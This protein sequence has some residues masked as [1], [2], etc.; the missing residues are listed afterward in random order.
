MTTSLSGTT[1]RDELALTGRTPPLFFADLASV[2]A[3]GTAAAQAHHL[4]RAF[5]ALELD[6]IL[7]Q[8]NAP[9]A[10]FREVPRL[11]PKLVSELHRRFWNLGISPLL[12]LID[13]AEVHVY[14]GLAT[15]RPDGDTPAAEDERLVVRL[16][17]VAQALE[18]RQL[19]LAIESGEI[20]HREQHAFD[21]NRRVDRQLLQNLKA[22][23]DAMAAVG[24]AR[25]DPRNLDNFLCRVVFT[26][27]LFDRRV[28]DQRY[29]RDA[30]LASAAT[31]RDLAEQKQL[32]R[33]FARLSEDFNGDL[34][35]D[36]LAAE[37]RE[38]RE[39]H[40]RIL[41][42]FL[43]GTDIVTGQGSFWPYDF[44]VIP[45]ETIS[46][47]YEH[48]LKAADPGAKK[49][50]GAFYTP[51]FLA[52]MTL[53]MALDGMKDLLG[54]R[55]LDPA[56]GSGVFLVGLFNRLAHEW[57][58]R[59]PEA[60]YTRRADGL[61]EILKHNLV[62]ADES[63]TAC[64]IA[65][66]SLYLALLDQLKP[67]QIRELQKRKR[68]LPP[69]VSSASTGGEGGT[70]HCGDFF[71]LPVNGRFDVAVGN[72]P[73]ASLSGP[74][75]PAERWCTSRN[76]P[77]ANRQIALAFVWK[78]AGHVSTDGRICFV[79]PNGVLFNH[80]AKALEFQREWLARHSVESVLNLS[81]F[82]RF[83]FEEAEFPAVVIRYRPTATGT[84]HVSYWSPKTDWR[85]LHAEVVSVAP[86][87]R[88][89]LAVSALLA[90]LKD[91]EAPL[92][93]KVHFWA[94]PRDIK[95][96]DRL[97]MY[98]RLEAITSQ[99]RSRERKRWLAGQGFIPE[100]TGKKPASKPNPWSKDQLFLDAKS[101]AID[102]FVIGRDASA[103]GHRFP[104]LL[105]PRTA[106]EI[107]E[108]PHVLVTKSLRAAYCGYPVLF[109]HA[110]QGIHG[111][112]VDRHLLQF[113]AA[114]FSSPLA[115]F[116]L[117]HTTSSWGVNRAEVHLAELLSAPFPLPV[118][119]NDPKR[120]QSIVAHVSAVV[121][122]AITEAAQLIVDRRSVVEAA[123]REITPLIYEYFD[124]DETERI[125]I[126]D[127]N[128]IVIPST[129]PTNAQSTLAT[130]KPPDTAA[131]ALYVDTLTSTLNHWARGG[132]Q[133]VSGRS[134]TA[135]WSGVGAVEL[136]RFGGAE[137]SRPAGDDK[138][139]LTTL[140]RLRNL[141]RKQLGSVELLRGLKV[142]HEDTL[143]LFKPL[144]MRFWT[145]TAALNDAD[146]IAASILASLPE[147]R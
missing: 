101:D 61:I 54:K 97:S 23:R 19:A 127:T 41:T 17:R 117:F 30:G 16:V 15:P 2:E 80:Q 7:C 126:E 89:N 133:R 113:L 111:P 110:L 92:P 86:E 145:R 25:L 99:P 47:I 5:E 60:D 32:Y 40:W 123:R 29:L 58:Q 100:P 103:L 107:F 3:A 129:R 105:R 35:S 147:R 34:F 44:S 121:D 51:R 13:A 119:T 39:A 84:K 88:T 31:L 135:V 49:E 70:I 76:L 134:M 62:G 24:P 98:P 94:T 46:A 90:D 9:I 75:R 63:P 112:Q 146:S 140:D 130:L 45:I 115:R 50:K 108:P 20:F 109:R 132:P 124:V 116:Y 78:T 137:P 55:F 120:A 87:D 6:G 118:D 138:E 33:L 69:L 96:I 27:Y 143:Y 4:R 38:I 66:F 1:W 93:W 22:T 85:V 56:C 141:Y 81:D 67:P 65:A 48:F 79:L 37:A 83:L 82:Q 10:Y 43:S 14:S 68:F 139:L 144:Q 42:S 21:R 125:T 95:T 104:W 74:E 106:H 102:L 128:E 28:I 71:D 26:S 73:W 77:I 36:D 72:P 18:V 122:R 131:Q 59:H 64:R 52:E 53:D 142:F 91:P 136:R 57:S 114:Y 12:V 11:T 8:D